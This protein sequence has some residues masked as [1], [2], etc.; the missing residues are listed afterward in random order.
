M[1]S[2][3]DFLTILQQQIPFQF[4]KSQEVVAQM[5]A[6]FVCAPAENQLFVL[7][8]Y[9]GTGKTTLVGALVRTLKGFRK[10]CI[11]LAPTGRS[12]KV[13]SLYAS[14]KAYTIH[15]CLYYSKMKDGVR[16]FSRRPNRLQNTIFIVDE[17]SMIAD[18]V[19][20]TPVF[21]NSSLLE[22]LFSYVFEGQNCQLLLVGD[23]AQLPPVHFEESPALDV[24]YIKRNF[25]LNA[26]SCSLVD[27]TRQSQNSGILYNATRLRNK[28]S[29]NE[30]SFPLFS[31]PVYPDCQRVD[32][33]E[34]EELLHSLYAKH[35]PD[36]IVVI[37]Y[38]NKRAYIYNQEIRHRILYREE[39][40]AAGDYL[41]AV[42]N[43]YFWIQDDREVGFLA[44]G[45]AMEILSINKRQELYG[46]HFADVTVRL[47]DYPNHDNVDI[48]I[49]LESL[50]SEN[51][52]LSEEQS[53]ALYHAVSEDYA[54]IPTKKE[55]Y[56]KM[57]SDPFLNA[58]QVKFSYAMTCHKTQGGQ[59]ACVLL[60]QGLI[61]D[62]ILTK[63][64]LRW[65]YTA[66]TRATQQVYLINF[67]DSFFES[68]V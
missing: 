18:G 9:A 59:W 25:S 29:R 22:D 10:N 17:A 30:C 27:V 26:N 24:D 55:F 49:I 41:I 16:I 20:D 38:S 53:E 35:E 31:P 1:L 43:N 36:D 21:G 42:K 5:L 2:K 50:D 13:F 19:V 11:L 48:K 7:N 64:Y 14:Q 45:D 63:S 4:T 57:K 68:Q 23:A 60:D 56:A 54:D 37:T 33:E 40:L 58:V 67:N 65:L 66:L 6:D 46:F 15:K 61:R 12:A 39:Q 8:G 51:A 62:G 34:L 44:N 3:N 52:S 32:G 47:C 28:M